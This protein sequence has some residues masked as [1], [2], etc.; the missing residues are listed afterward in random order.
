VQ[1]WRERL[2]GFA[3]DVSTTM[4]RFP[5]AIC[6]IAIATFLSLLIINEVV[7]ET[8]NWVRLFAGT[9]AAAILA[10][11]GV[12]CIERRG[13]TGW[14]GPLLLYVLPLLGLVAFQIADERFALTYLLPLPVLIWLSLSPSAG[15][16]S[17][18][19]EIY[20]WTNNRAVTTAIVAVAGFGLIVLGLLAI[21]RSLSILFRVEVGDLFYRG[22]LPIVGFLLLPVYW[23]S[24]LPVVSDPGER[25]LDARDFLVR[26]IAFIGQFVLVPFIFIY[27]LIL[28]AY[29]IQIV[30][31]GEVPQGV[32][33]WMVSYFLIAGMVTWILVHP[34]FLRSRPMVV[35]FRRGWF[36]LTLVP[37]ALLA[38]AV[39]L[40][41]DAFG[42]TPLRVLLIAGGVWGA[43]LAGAFLITRG[44]A[45]IRLIP[46][47]GGALLLILGLGPLTAENLSRWQQTARLDRLLA[48]NALADGWAWSDAD[49][50]RARA[51]FDFLYFDQ[52]RRLA[53]EPLLARHNVS[54]EDADWQ[55][56][57]IRTALDIEN[58]GTEQG[59]I[60]SYLSHDAATRPVALSATPYYR[61]QITL[62]PGP[63]QTEIGTA[64]LSLA[65]TA[66]AVAQGEE[67]ETI[68]LDAWL[69][70]QTGEILADPL[71]VF[72]SDGHTYA[73]LIIDMTVSRLVPD[74]ADAIEYINALVFSADSDAPAPG[75]VTP[76]P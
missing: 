21:D 57:T 37:L 53:L 66:L 4:R 33:G 16:R 1:D 68:D 56:S 55:G 62:N 5:L 46:A 43:I 25:D 75:A 10:T 38:V 19:E 41:V 47:L 49:R 31:L 40:R 42:L 6:F 28:H 54:P 32:L 70:R 35:L 39:W 36:V 20:W 72:E 61:G 27:A 69:D 18:G 51:A 50:S 11:A 30:V 65:G 34:P 7:P 8:E 52:S 48:A 23:L 24:T 58:V 9:A 63:W 45:D 29:A 74:E 76:R 22:L 67:V 14:L 12:L 2:A 15:A 44:K 59:P 3:P 60:Y 17:D 71:I 13:N 26:A 64:A 73:L